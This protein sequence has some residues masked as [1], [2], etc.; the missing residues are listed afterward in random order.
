MSEPVRVATGVSELDRMLGG[1]FI[2]DNVVWHD[3]AGSLAS[4]FCLNFIMA[5]QSQARPVVYVTF[6]RSPKNLLDKLDALGDDS[7]LTVLDC[8]S[9]GKGAGSD[10][11]MRFYDEH[12][13]SAGCRVVPVRNPDDPR[14][15]G[16]A[17]Q[18]AH[19]GLKGKGDVRFIIESLTGMQD[20]WGGE[21]SI[22]RFY[23]HT[24]PRLYELQT[25][26]YWVMEKEAHSTRL[27]AAINQ[28]AQVVID[29]SVKRGTTSLTVVKAES[30]DS[31]SHHKPFNYWT[32]GL[33]VTF[34]SQRRAAGRIDLG[35]RLKDL[36]TKKGLSQTELA[37]QVGV[38]P[39]T[40]SQVESNHIYPSL[41]ALLKMAEV[42]SVDIASFFQEGVGEGRRVV[43]PGDESVE[44]RLGNL[45][46]RAVSAQLLTPVDLEV[47]AEPYVIEIQPKAS[48]P[49]HF[50]VHKG[51]EMGYLLS[52]R[53][54]VTINKGMHTVRAGDVVYL[55]TEMPTL[56]H[57]PGRTPA[58]LLWIKVR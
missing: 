34:D 57:N 6:D 50:F 12:D 46:D 24:C 4:V 53:L 58:R 36:R 44:V 40:I 25:I 16:E 23:T 32:K 33:N 15:V 29:L 17:L 26:A 43:F 56:W 21:D 3:D 28:I 48:L 41:P 22:L 7:D 30:R 54:H 47:K 45:P 31:E 55:G 35:L 18:E 10:V 14:Q 9:W 52:G 19:A 20:L 5:S 13:D 39:S 11:F 27:R 38:T 2:G 42:L 49:S 8:F 51:E 1:L 37:K